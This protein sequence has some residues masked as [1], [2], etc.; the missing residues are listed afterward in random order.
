MSDEKELT[1]EEL[2]LLEKTG[3]MAIDLTKALEHDNAKRWL[4]DGDIIFI[5]LMF[6]NFWF[7]EAK[8][9]SGRYKFNHGNARKYLEAKRRMRRW[10]LPWWERFKL[11]WHMAKE[12]NFYDSDNIKPKD[13]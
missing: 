7:I 11:A 13:E 12:E 10:K 1:S 9:K 3:Q 8:H 5:N 4:V 6:I 2:A